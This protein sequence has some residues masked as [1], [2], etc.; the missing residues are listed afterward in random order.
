MR[1]Y[2]ITEGVTV[3]LSVDE[4]QT[5]YGWFQSARG[6]SMAYWDEDSKS[7]FAKMGIDQG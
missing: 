6:E 7:I 1:A 4:I 2:Q 3:Y 5:I